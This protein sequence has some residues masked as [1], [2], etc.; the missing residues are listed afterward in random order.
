MISDS[1][2]KMR[3]GWGRGLALSLGIIMLCALFFVGGKFWKGTEKIY[4]STAVL[5]V[6]HPLM[7]EEGETL[8]GFLAGEKAAMISDE[9]LEPVVSDLKLAEE[10][11]LTP[12]QSLTTLRERTAVLKLSDEEGHSRFSISLRAPDAKLTRAIAAR[13][14]KEYQKQRNA[15]ARLAHEKEVEALNRQIEAQKKM[16][17]QKRKDMEEVQ[18]ALREKETGG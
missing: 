14:A 5:Q 3:K 16:V 6:A 12:S 8:E 18:R 1:E 15:L 9:V 17:E 7:F 10:W 11:S 2:R 13:V 4:E